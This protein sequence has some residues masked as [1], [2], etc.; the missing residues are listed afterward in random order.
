V[1]QLFARN[2]F[3]A[4]TIAA[5]AAGQVSAETICGLWRKPGLVH[6]S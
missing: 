3:A 2:G 1:Q 6:A 5:I 4:T